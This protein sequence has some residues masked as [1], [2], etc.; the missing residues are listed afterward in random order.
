MTKGNTGNNHI[1][2]L[3]HFLDQFLFQFA[4][5]ISIEILLDIFPKYE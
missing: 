2:S 5:K 1:V 3:G 4:L